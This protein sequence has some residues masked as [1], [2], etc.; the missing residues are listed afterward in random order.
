MGRAGLGGLGDGPLARR[1][2]AQAAGQS[3]RRH[4]PLGAARCAHSSPWR[5]ASGAAAGGDARHLRRPG[6]SASRAA[7]GRE[8]VLGWIDAE[9]LL[10]AP[11]GR[12]APT[13]STPTGYPQDVPVTLAWGELDRLRRPTVAG[14]PAGRRPLP[15]PARGRPHADLGRPRA[16]RPH[17]ARGQLRPGGR[18]SSGR[19]QGTRGNRKEQR[20]D[21][22]ED[23]EPA[24]AVERLPGRRPRAAARAC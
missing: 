12:C 18:L 14:A 5:P 19:V 4:A 11:T 21:R 22:R 13:S 6:P 9:R 20:L 16:D 2:L 3:P 1:P 24:V 10:T 7:A 23:R 17:P 15:G 8:L